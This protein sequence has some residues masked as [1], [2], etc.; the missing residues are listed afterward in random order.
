SPFREA[1]IFFGPG[2]TFTFDEPIVAGSE[3][4]DIFFAVTPSVP[5]R[6]LCK[7]TIN[8]EVVLHVFPI[9]SN[10]RKIAQEKGTEALITYF[11]HH[12]IEPDFDLHREP[13]V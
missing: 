2:H 9:T 13:F 1:D 8:A 3:M 4:T 5:M 11:E 6:Q 10:E 7:A 12:K